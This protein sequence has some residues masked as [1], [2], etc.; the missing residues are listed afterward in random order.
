MSRDAWKVSLQFEINGVSVALV[1]EK[2][3]R[4]AD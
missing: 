3:K 4:K 1:N 2:K